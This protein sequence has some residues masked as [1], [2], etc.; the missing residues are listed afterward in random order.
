M[1]ASS[2]KRSIILNACNTTAVHNNYASLHKRAEKLYFVLF[3]RTCE[4][5][6]AYLINAR[7][8]YAY[9]QGYAC[10]ETRVGRRKYNDRRCMTRS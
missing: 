4:K 6:L 3:R 9:K 7:L 2:C 10:S 8:C 5:T 1:Y